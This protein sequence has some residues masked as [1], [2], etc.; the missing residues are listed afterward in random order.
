MSIIETLT[1]EHT[2]TVERFNKIYNSLVSDLQEEERAALSWF[3]R[4]LRT[5][6]QMEKQRC[7]EHTRQILGGFIL[8]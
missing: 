4:G 7:Y 1:K 3:S 2:D 6:D 8:R 5:K